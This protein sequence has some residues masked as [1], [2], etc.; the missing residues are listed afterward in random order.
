MSSAVAGMQTSIETSKVYSKNPMQGTL[1][2]EN[3]ALLE[4]AANADPGGTSHWTFFTNMTVQGDA[5]GDSM[6]YIGYSQ[7]HTLMA[8]VFQPPILMKTVCSLASHCF[9]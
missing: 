8:G 9:S 7:T 6:A 3:S 2:I 5:K 1:E 4:T